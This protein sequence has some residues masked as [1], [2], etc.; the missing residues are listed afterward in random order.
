MLFH[1]LHP[2][3]R[4]ELRL[5]TIL[6]WL[7]DRI[8][9]IA[10]PLTIQLLLITPLRC[11]PSN[12]HPVALWRLD[13]GRGNIAWDSAL[14]P[15]HL[16]LVNPKWSSDGPMGLRCALHFDG[17]GRTFAYL[18]KRVHIG[19]EGTI[20]LWLRP[21]KFGGVQVLFATRWTSTPRITF[22]IRDHALVL[23]DEWWRRRNEIIAERAFSDNDIGKWIHI[24]ATWSH[25]GYA[26]FRDGK[27]I[28]KSGRTAF[29]SDADRIS[30]GVH[31]WNLRGGAYCGD[32]ALVRLMRIA[33]KREQLGIGKSPSELVTGKFHQRSGHD[34][35]FGICNPWVGLREVGVRWSRCGGGST[36]LGDWCK[37]MPAQNTIIWDAGD[38]EMVHYHLA[39]G[40]HPALLL[41]YTPKWA[42]SDPTGKGDKFFPPRDLRDYR[43]FV[44]QMVHHYREY[45]KFWEVWNE[46]NGAGTFFKANV[47][48]LVEL[49]KTAWCAAKRADPNAK[50]I[51]PGLAGSDPVYLERCY[52]LGVA[53]YFDI[54]A[55]HP[56]QWGRVFDEGYY[57]RGAI[58]RIR[59]VMDRWGDDAKP[60][61]LNEF[62]WSTARVSEGDQARLLAQAMTFFLTCADLGVEKM[63]WFTVKD[64]GGAGYGIIRD[65]GTRKPAFYAFKTVVRKLDGKYYIGRVPIEGVRAFVFAPKLSVS[66]S[67]QR[68]RFKTSLERRRHRDAVI[69][70]WS[71]TL[72]T[73]KVTLPIDCAKVDGTVKVTSLVGEVRAVKV[74]GRGLEIDVTPAPQYIDVPISAILELERAPPPKPRPGRKAPDDVEPFVWTSLYIPQNTMRLWLMRG[75]RN[76]VRITVHND[77]ERHQRGTVHIALEG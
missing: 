50:I 74:N 12:F 68:G 69:A 28:A 72:K 33:L 26:L 49:I 39:E 38:W 27:L 41:C 46:P 44:Y 6:S 11:A 65:N 20:E 37:H 62:G 40:L 1:H 71:P 31:V 51:F 21:H 15:Y 9:H 70:L 76:T 24:A 47:D 7:P 42:S 35:P 63:F 59:K 25:N 34:S 64:W 58:E 13:E 5:I 17:T 60:I 53:P 43:K 10:L 23:T 57:A 75:E 30:L 2:G 16:T 32:M 36:S 48:K 45:V 4:G 18:E 29:A 14:V 3:M 8:V 52:E 22:F 73:V 19:K 56:Y 67:P 77:S 61:W 54:M 66:A 55:F